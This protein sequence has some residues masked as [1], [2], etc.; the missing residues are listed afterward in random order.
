MSRPIGAIPLPTSKIKPPIQEPKAI[1]QIQSGEP[2]WM[3]YGIATLIH[4]LTKTLNHIPAHH[5]W[6]K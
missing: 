6:Y 1:F 3:H 4:I 2:R 5:G